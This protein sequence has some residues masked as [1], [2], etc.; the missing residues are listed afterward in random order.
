MIVYALASECRYVRRIGWKPYART[1]SNLVRVTMAMAST[2]ISV[3]AVS[4]YAENGLFDF[5][6]GSHTGYGFLFSA[7]LFAVVLRGTAHPGC[8]R[9]ADLKSITAAA[10]GAGQGLRAPDRIPRTGI[11]NNESSS[12]SAEI[13]LH[14][15]RVLRSSWQADR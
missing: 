6:P 8:L 11:L 14:L 2:A 10:G 5:L 12:R 7:G 3:K 1:W 13:G 15:P 4:I 9:C